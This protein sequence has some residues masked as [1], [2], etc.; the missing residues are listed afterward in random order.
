MR[1]PMGSPPASRPTVGGLSF[2][3]L[4]QEPVEDLSVVAISGGPNPNHHDN[5]STTP[6]AK[7]RPVLWS[8]RVTAHAV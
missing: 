1:I 3:M 4:L 8:V 2:S 7:F 5:T 6:W